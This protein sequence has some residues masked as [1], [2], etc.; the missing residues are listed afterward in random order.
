MSNE[1]NWVQDIL[2]NQFARKGGE[3]PSWEPLI[4][5]VRA[6]LQRA[7]V[8]ELDRIIEIVRNYGRRTP[9]EGILDAMLRE[10]AAESSRRY[11]NL[12]PPSSDANNNS[13]G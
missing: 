3:G 2:D 1:R 6:R 12:F 13:R 8:D 7:L 10:R 4:R 5:F 9:L 11:Y